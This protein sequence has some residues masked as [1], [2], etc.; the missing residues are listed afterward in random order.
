[1]FCLRW[2]RLFSRLRCLFVASDDFC[3]SG[4]LFLAGTSSWACLSATSNLNEFL[5]KF[6][7]HVG[8]CCGTRACRYITPHAPGLSSLASGVWIVWEL[9]HS[10]CWEPSSTRRGTR[11]SPCFSATHLVDFAVFS[12][13]K[14][15]TYCLA[16]RTKHERGF[17][18]SSRATVFSR[19]KFVWAVNLC[20]NLFATKVS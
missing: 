3:F 6:S 13:E 10:D 4:V 8:W 7:K 2:G 12:R 19:L 18:T 16:I 15:R 11:T 1:M 14:K 9:H 17:S 20:K 5:T